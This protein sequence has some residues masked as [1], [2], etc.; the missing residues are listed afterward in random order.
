[1][2]SFASFQQ[3]IEQYSKNQHDTNVQVKAAATK[4]SKVSLSGGAKAAVPDSISRKG[5]EENAGFA[6]RL[7]KDGG[8]EDDGRTVLVSDVLA[9]SCPL[10]AQRA[11][12]P[13]CRECLPCRASYLSMYHPPSNRGLN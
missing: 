13:C 6:Q 2:A 7:T 10:R 5:N 11:A 9:G 1:M 4:L 12:T 3:E 8:A